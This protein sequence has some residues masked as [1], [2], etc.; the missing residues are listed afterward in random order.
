M[1]TTSWSQV[2]CDLAHRT[3]EYIFDC[4][5][6][7]EKGKVICGKQRKPGMVSF[8]RYLINVWL[9]LWWSQILATLQSYCNGPEESLTGLR[10]FLRS[11][12]EFLADMFGG[13]IN[14]PNR[15][16][17]KTTGHDFPICFPVDK[18]KK[19]NVNLGYILKI[20]SSLVCFLNWYNWF[21][22]LT[23]VLTCSQSEGGECTTP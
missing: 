19:L 5:F 12:A 17:I 11:L 8:Y 7:S 20:F 4:V 6:C 21:C 13:P 16:L 3:V 15:L 22:L 2:I 1:I 14:S 18:L 9:S 10:S 23:M